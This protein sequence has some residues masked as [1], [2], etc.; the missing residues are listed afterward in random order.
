MLLAGLQKVINKAIE[1]LQKFGKNPTLYEEIVNFFLGVVR[2]LQLQLGADFVIQIIRMLLELATVSNGNSQA[3]NKLLQ[4]LIFI[5]QQS[6]SAASILMN[7]LLKMMLDDL[8]PLE[9]SQSAD[10]SVNL[11][12]LFDAILQNHWNF[13]QKIPTIVGTARNHQEDVMKIFTAYGQFLCNDT[14]SQDP[15]VILAFQNL[16]QMASFPSF[17]KRADFNKKKRLFLFFFIA[18]RNFK[19]NKIYYNKTLQR[20]FERNL[21]LN[22]E[23][24]GSSAV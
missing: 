16:R 18:N 21:H 9:R 20:L 7:D 12:T 1:L 3:L 5:V 23:P 22:Q 15:N 24:S 11:Y 6:G 17:R 19:Q 2:C 8:L 4:M 13:L 14:N 10:I